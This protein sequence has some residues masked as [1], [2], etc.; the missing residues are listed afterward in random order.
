MDRMLELCRPLSKT[1]HPSR[2]CGTS[3]MAI[4]QV[5][6]R[7]LMSGRDAARLPLRGASASL[8]RLVRGV[9]ALIR[10][11]LLRDSRP[12]LPASPKK[13]R[14]RSNTSSQR[15]E[16]LVISADEEIGPL[17]SVRLWP[18][19]REIHAVADAQIH[20][21]QG[22]PHERRA[23]CRVSGCRA[24]CASHPRS[25]ARSPGRASRRGG[26]CPAAS[27]EPCC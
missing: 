24:R 6:P 12:D 18:V 4:D 19:E 23:S 20:A 27:R 9:L 21:S 5:P 16:R 1:A 22:P 13:V 25:N 10:H 8:N 11:S 2:D 17:P 14:S 3:E 7:T 15:S 26:F